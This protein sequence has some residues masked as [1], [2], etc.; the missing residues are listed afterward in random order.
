MEASAFEMPVVTGMNDFSRKY[1]KDNDI[2]CPYIL[3]NT[4]N[5]LKDKLRPLIEH[6]DLR[7]VEGRKSYEYAKKTHSEESGVKRF[8]E[9]VE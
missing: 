3:A 2:N 6:V 7:R 1:I 5:M 9:L 4:L 8:L